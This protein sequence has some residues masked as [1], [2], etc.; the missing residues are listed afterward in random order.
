MLQ[1]WIIRCG[2]VVEGLP[3]LCKALGSIPSSAKYYHSLVKFGSGSVPNLGLPC[4]KPWTSSTVDVMFLSL[5]FCVG[6]HPG[7]SPK[8]PSLR[9]KYT[10]FHVVQHSSTEV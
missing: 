9:W 10:A 4:A 1:G 2:L 6:R 7:V 8:F 3:D 5:F